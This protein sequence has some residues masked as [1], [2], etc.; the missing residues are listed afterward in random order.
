MKEY[1]VTFNGKQYG[2]FTEEAFKMLFQMYF[3]NLTL[4]NQRGEEFAKLE[5]E[6]IEA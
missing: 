6:V 5:F 2:T 4:A 1:K 3:E